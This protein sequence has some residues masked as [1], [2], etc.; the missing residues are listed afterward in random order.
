[1]ARHSKW[2][3]IKHR[4]A[5]QDAQRGKVFSLHSKLISIAAQ[6]WSDPEKNPG[7]AEA[8]SK[9]K[10]AN[11]P[12]DNIDRA[13]KRWSG[14]DKDA[15]QILEIVYEWYA[16]GWVA[17]LVPSLTDN[18][19]RTASEI[20]HIFSKYGWNMW[21]L[22]SVSWIFSKK[23]V[24]VYSKEKY[25]LDTI[26]EIAIETDVEDIVEEW[27]IIKIITSIEDFYTVNTFMKDKN[28]YCEDSGVDYIYESVIDVIEFDKALKITKMIEA[29]EENEDVEDVYLNA[30]I[31]DELQTEVDEFIEQNT[32]RT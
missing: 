23:W 9:A 4:K 13:I 27:D 19:N 1:M 20:R 16:P 12:N 24:I 17:V 5:A 10:I 11:V 26:E 3:N 32:F 25:N 22:G 8:I 14:E 30:N 7:L 6:W 31:S 29:F 2:H 18:K 21:E 15:S 28:F